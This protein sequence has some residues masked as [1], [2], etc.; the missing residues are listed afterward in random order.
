MHKQRLDKKAGLAAAA[1]AGYKNVLI[2]RVFRLLRAAVHG[3]PFRLCQRDI[4]FKS[5][6]K[7]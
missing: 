5:I 3:E 7:V 2:P 1:T 4:I 6:D